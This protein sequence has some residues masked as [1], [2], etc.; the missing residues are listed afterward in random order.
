MTRPLTRSTS[1][2]HAPRIGRR[3]RRTRWSTLLVAAL[4]VGGAL[5]LLGGL[6][7][8]LVDA[9]QPLAAGGGVLDAPAYRVAY[10]DAPSV[11]YV[12]YEHGAPVTYTIELSNDGPLPI[13]VDDVPL[14]PLRDDQRLVRPTAVRIAPADAKEVDLEGLAP[15]EP[16]RLWPGGSR[17]V[18]VT[19]EFANC[20]YFTERAI[21]LIV[22]QPVGW[23][24]LGWSRTSTIALSDQLA[25]RSPFMRECPGRVMDRGA[26]TRT[27]GPAD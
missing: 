20:A 26:L 8:V 9:S 3:A 18:V 4:T 16:F 5:S 12:A 27:G 13:T 19:G 11:S 24:V 17:I 22:E 7:A 15:F 10:S 25:I 2:R 23:S 6:A 14:A 21:D 1:L